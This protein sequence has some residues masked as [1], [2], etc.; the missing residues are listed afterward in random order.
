METSTKSLNRRID[1]FCRFC[2]TKS[3]SLVPIQSSMGDVPI[4]KMFV[5][6]TGVTIDLNDSYPQKACSDCCNKLESAYNV[7][8]TFLDSVF[9]LQSFLEF[10]KSKAD[11]ED[12][13]EVKNEPFKSGSSESSSEEGSSSEFE[14]EEVEAPP[15]R[16]KITKVVDLSETKTENKKPRQIYSQNS[17]ETKEYKCKYERCDYVT[18]DYR[19]YSYHTKSQH[20]RKFECSI[21]HKR[22]PKQNQLAN[23]ANS[24]LDKNQRPFACEHC[25][26]KFTSKTR[27]IDHSRVHTGVRP[28][29]CTECGESFTSSAI[30]SNHMLK[31]S[32]PQHKCQHCSREF[33]YKGDFVRHVRIHE[34]E[35][36]MQF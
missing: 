29:L 9:K 31:H 2:L 30:L 23:H 26:R 13:F 6:L 8:K 28:Y 22:F 25:D 16:R 34:E 35:H 14:Y 19:K 33:R 21:C 20:E 24:H 7:R 3:P 18:T 32:K 11:S 17:D 12:D 10:H 36:F 5:L 15:K 27:L 4:P 1:Q